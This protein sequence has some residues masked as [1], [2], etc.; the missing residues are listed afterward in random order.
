MRGKYASAYAKAH[1]IAL[2]DPEEAI[3]LPSEEAVNKA[4]LFDERSADIRRTHQEFEQTPVIEYSA[5]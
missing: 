3:A 2:L 5:A 4:L 1:N